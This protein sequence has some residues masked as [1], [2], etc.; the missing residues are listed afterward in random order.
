MQQNRQM[1]KSRWLELSMHFHLSMGMCEKCSR[2]LLPGKEETSKPR[3]HAG[4]MPAG[5]GGLED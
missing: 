4:A 1:S 2:S 3:D 5:L